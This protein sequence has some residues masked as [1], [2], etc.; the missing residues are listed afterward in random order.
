[1]AR[2]VVVTGAS[3]NIGR[4]VA[5]DLASAGFQAVVCARDL[6]AVAAVADEINAAGGAAIGVRADVSDPDSVA[7]MVHAAQER[8]GR[9]DALVNNAVARVNRLLVDMSLAEW[10]RAHGVILDGAF[11]CVKAVLPQMC[12]GGWGRIVNLI[13]TSA[14]AGSVGRAGVVS[15]KSG[16]IGFTRAV[17][18]EAAPYGVTVNAVSPGRIATTRGEWT[19]QGQASAALARYDELPNP[20]V[21]RKGTE[22]D[23]SAMI[24]FLCSDAASYLTGQ[25]ICV[26]GGA[27]LS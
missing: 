16:L 7:A 18:L 4:R 20:P 2:T 10:R 19:I 27:Y 1:M 3:R 12:E 26:N 25:N 15:A 23:V 9:V 5:L 14:M 17:A 24:A 13:G 11:N 8:F 21:G 6:K 22:A